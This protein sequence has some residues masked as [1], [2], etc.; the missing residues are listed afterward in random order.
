MA[1]LPYFVTRRWW[2]ALAGFAAASLVLIAVAHVLFGIDN[3]TSDGYAGSFVTALLNNLQSTQEFCYGKFQFLR[4]STA[5]NDVS[6][7][8]GLCGVQERV[9]LPVVATISG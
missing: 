1:L 5:T 6:V 4:Y 3:F 7:G 9:P 8:L 2:R